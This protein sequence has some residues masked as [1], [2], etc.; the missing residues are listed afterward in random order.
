MRVPIR[1]LRSAIARNYLQFFLT[2]FL[3]YRDDR[4]SI[5]TSTF[6]DRRLM[7]IWTTSDQM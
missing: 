3:D 4:Y 6:S 7:A 1:A 5:G 2:L